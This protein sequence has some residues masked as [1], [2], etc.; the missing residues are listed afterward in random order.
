[1]SLFGEEKSLQ[2]EC[3]ANALALKP[4]SKRFLTRPSH[5]NDIVFECSVS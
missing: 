5:L 4:D 3:S 2:S 1:M